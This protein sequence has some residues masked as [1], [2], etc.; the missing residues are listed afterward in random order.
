M[1]ICYTRALNYANL[2][3]AGWAAHALIQ[4]SV[5]GRSPSQ[6]RLINRAADKGMFA[7]SLIDDTCTVNEVI[8]FSPTGDSDKAAAFYMILHLGSE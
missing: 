8:Y 7:A 5:T 6:P 3:A 2:R 1:D 4:M